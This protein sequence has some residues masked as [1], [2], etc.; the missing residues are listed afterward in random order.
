MICY[1]FAVV[2]FYNNASNLFIFFIFII[3]QIIA[4]YIV[5]G[6]FAV[7]AVA[8]HLFFVYRT[9]V[10]LWESVYS[11]ILMVWWWKIVWNFKWNQRL[12]HNCTSRFIMLSHR[13]LFPYFS[14]SFEQATVRATFP[15]FHNFQTWS[16]WQLFNHAT[17]ELFMKNS[18]PT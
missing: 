18:D 9:V 6:Y 8:E 14:I 2:S 17:L 11:F 1:D 10:L 12:V 4:F 3:N 16:C 15:I 7:T 13:T 5:Y